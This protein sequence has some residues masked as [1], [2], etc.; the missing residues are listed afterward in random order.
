MNSP[1]LLNPQRTAKVAVRGRHSWRCPISHSPIHLMVDLGFVQ[2]LTFLAD[3]PWWRWAGGAGKHGV[4]ALEFCDQGAGLA[5][6]AGP[7][8]ESFSPMSWHAMWCPRSL[9]GEVSSDSP[10]TLWCPGAWFPQ[11]VPKV[12]PSLQ[13]N[14]RVT[15][16][17]RGGGASQMTAVW[18]VAR[19]TFSGGGRGG[20]LSTH[21]LSQRL[22]KGSLSFPSQ[23]RLTFDACSVMMLECRPRSCARRQ[24]PLCP[25]SVN[26]RAV[27]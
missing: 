9:S 3:P 14:C 16:E 12:L 10:Q 2:C 15:A 4:W 23:S 17:A 26:A 11:D 27:K 6:A 21:C 1:L 19:W 18:G 20:L 24:G 8:L 5:P 25:E 13:H 22:P 7:W